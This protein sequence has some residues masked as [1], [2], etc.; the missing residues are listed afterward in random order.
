MPLAPDLMASFDRWMLIPSL[1]GAVWGALRALAPAESRQRP[2]YV[3]LSISGVLL[4]G[5]YCFTRIGMSGAW[6]MQQQLT[7]IMCSILL[8]N[9]EG[10]IRSNNVAQA[11]EPPTG[12]RL[13]TRALLLSSCVPILGFFASGFLIVSELVVDSLP[14]AAMVFV[15]AALILGVLKLAIDD[16]YRSEKQNSSGTNNR[17]QFPLLAVVMFLLMITITLFPGWLLHQCEAEFARVF[18][19][20]EQTSSADFAESA[21]ND[22][23]SAP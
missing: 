11:N 10:Q 9:D 21:S 6:L 13:S 8:L 16:H 14:L 1:G 4:L 22:R 2:A 7:V 17:R 5:C 18:R 15:V 20:F 23:Q 3:Y 12:T 19:R